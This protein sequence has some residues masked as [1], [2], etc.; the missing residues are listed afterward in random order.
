MEVFKSRV[1][2]EVVD[3]PVGQ[4]EA[5]LV[6]ADDGGDTAEVIEKV[7][8]H[9]ALPVVLQV[10]EPARDDDKRWTGAMN[11]VGD[12]RAIGRATEPDRLLCSRTSARSPRRAGW[13]RLDRHR[14]AILR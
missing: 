14:I 6:V 10:A 13:V 9:R 12:P 5:A 3:I 4:T 2:R 1:Q 8:P 7:P 11:R